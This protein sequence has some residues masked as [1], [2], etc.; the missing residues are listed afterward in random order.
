MYEKVSRH[1]LNQEE[2]SIFLAETPN[3]RPNL[4]YLSIVGVSSTQRYDK[5]WGLPTL[6]G[7]SKINAF[8]RIKGKVWDCINGWKEKFSLIGKEGDYV[9]ADK[10]QDKRLSLSL[11]YHLCIS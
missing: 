7:R 3:R 1:K 2:T 4:I 5:Y 6:I 8:S 10:A 9:E 11:I